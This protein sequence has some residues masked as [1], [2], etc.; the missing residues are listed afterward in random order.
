VP[1]PSSIS[2]NTLLGG[3]VKPGPLISE[4]VSGSSGLMTQS[5]SGN[6]E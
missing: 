3:H 2:T 5:D 6:P 1:A 4:V